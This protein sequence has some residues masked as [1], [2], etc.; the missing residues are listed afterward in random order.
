[1][2]ETRYMRLIPWALHRG[3]EQFLF[4]CF[5]HSNNLVIPGRKKNHETLTILKKSTSHTLDFCYFS[6]WFYC[7]DPSAH[8]LQVSEK[9]AEKSGHGPVWIKSAGNDFHCF[10]QANFYVCVRPQ[11]CKE[12][13]ASKVLIPACRQDSGSHFSNCSINDN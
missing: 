6:V 3:S 4:I 1:M 10:R 13:K 9:L 5:P 12:L 7:F 2:Q 8:S 11:V